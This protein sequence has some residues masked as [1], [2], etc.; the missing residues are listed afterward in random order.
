MNFSNY[1][2]KV[3]E[4]SRF[5]RQAG[6]VSGEAGNELLSNLYDCY[7]ILHRICWGGTL[8]PCEIGFSYRMTRAF[9]YAAPPWN[10]K[11][12]K[13]VF[14]V[15]LCSLCSDLHIMMI[16]AHEMTHIWQYAQR[17]SG[18]H[19]KDFYREMERIGIIGKDPMIMTENSAFAYVMFM[20]SL[21]NINLQNNMKKFLSTEQQRR[22]KCR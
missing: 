9:A 17:R 22:K 21:K 10:G 19:G 15:N 11:K 3:A 12:A 6:K 1:F 5:D 7:N 2:V 14:N 13:I 4:K 16:L 18:G 8:I 20:Y